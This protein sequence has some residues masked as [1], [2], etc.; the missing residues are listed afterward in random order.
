MEDEE[1]ES[2][3]NYFVEGVEEVERCHGGCGE[4]L[5]HTK[6]SFCDD[7]TEKLENKEKKCA[8]CRKVLPEG[9]RG[10]CEECEE[11][12]YEPPTECRECGDELTGIESGICDVCLDAAL[13][14]KTREYRCTACGEVFE[15]TRAE[16]PSCNSC[17]T[18]VDRAVDDTDLSEVQIYLI[19]TGEYVKIGVSKDPETRRKSIQSATPLPAEIA[20]TIK[21]KEPEIVERILHRKFAEY[22]TPTGREWFKL[23]DR[24]CHILKQVDIMT[25]KEA[26]SKF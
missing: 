18:V 24:V 6:R 5:S 1:V 11:K 26:N 15:G 10:F 21:S 16:T 9:E 12:E 23:P 2:A 7:C 3:R 20:T 19:E 13:D 4:D 25:A 14:E 17:G 8:D 22:Q